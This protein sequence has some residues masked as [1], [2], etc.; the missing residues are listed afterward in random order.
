VAFVEWL[1]GRVFGLSDRWWRLLTLVVLGALRV[2]GVSGLA[3]PA[4]LCHSMGMT[5]TKA[6]KIEVR[7]SD[8][9]WQSKHQPGRDERWIADVRIVEYVTIKATGAP[10]VLYEYIGDVPKD[11]HR[12]GFAPVRWIVG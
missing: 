6:S 10:I 11:V 7:T 2:P 5:T 4:L 12:N 8:T 3:S 1:N 9:A